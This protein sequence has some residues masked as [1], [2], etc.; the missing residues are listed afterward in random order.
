M[1]SGGY[2]RSRHNDRSDS[3]QRQPTL[4]PSPIPHSRQSDMRHEIRYRDYNPVPQRKDLAK[5]EPLLPSQSDA[6]SSTP[7]SSYLHESQNEVFRLSPLSAPTKLEILRSREGTA[8]R[9]RREEEKAA[10]SAA[11]KRSIEEQGSVK[12]MRKPKPLMREDEQEARKRITDE[13]QEIREERRKIREANGLPALTREEE[14]LEFNREFK[15]MNRY[16]DA[17]QYFPSGRKGS[18]KELGTKRSNHYDCWEPEH[19]RLYKVF[20]KPNTRSEQGGGS[21]RHQIAQRH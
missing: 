11:K 21:A 2:R 14:A 12:R 1:L 19:Q 17:Q 4:S 18:N 3:K 5:V 9:M 16:P 10:K 7:P 15:H 13:N 20:R 6:R 8:A